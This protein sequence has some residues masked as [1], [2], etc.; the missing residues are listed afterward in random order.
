MI[1]LG[2]PD[3]VM[4]AQSTFRAILDAIARPG[5][6]QPIGQTIVAPEPFS[7]GAAAIALTLCDHDA[8]VW[9][10]DR[11]RANEAVGEWLRFHCGC[12]LVANPGDAAFAFAGNPEDFPPFDAFDQGTGDYPDRSTTIV[13]GVE[14]FDVQPCLKLAGPGIR[15]RISF[16]ARP[17]PLDIA[18]RLARNRLLFPRGVDLFL[19]TATAVA[20]L[21]RSVRIVEN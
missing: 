16:G 12:P 19:A 3:P 7:S 4:Q 21:P 14:S 9:L 18:E 1:S 8:P 6:V 20:G 15:D 11:L 17:L 5:K 13:L 10:D 2:F